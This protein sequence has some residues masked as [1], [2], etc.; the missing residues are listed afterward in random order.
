MA[1]RKKEALAEKNDRPT[2]WKTHN[3]GISLE[4]RILSLP[5][6]LDVNL[7]DSSYRPGKMLG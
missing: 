6:L 5:I 4:N 1:V 3:Y 2:F 7:S